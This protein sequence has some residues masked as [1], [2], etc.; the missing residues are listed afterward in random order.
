MTSLNLAGKYLGTFKT[1]MNIVIGFDTKNGC[2]AKA[3]AIS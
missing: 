1:L 3:K 2:F